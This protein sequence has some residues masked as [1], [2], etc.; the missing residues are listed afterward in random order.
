MYADT[1]LVIGLTLAVFAIPAMVS[2]YSE[3][4]APRVAAFAVLVAGGLVIWAVTS[5]P[6]G[7]TLTEIPETIIGVIGR[8][9]P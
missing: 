7:Y 2:A 4:R 5:K 6:G 9:L 1:A 8:V 3:G